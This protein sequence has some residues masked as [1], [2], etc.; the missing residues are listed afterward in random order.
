MQGLAL[1]A[2]A[3]GICQA[4]TRCQMRQELKMDK[5]FLEKGATRGEPG[6]QLLWPCALSPIINN[7]QVGSRMVPGLRGLNN[8]L[9]QTCGHPTDGGCRL[10]VRCPRV[11][12]WVRWGHGVLPWL[13][14]L[15]PSLTPD[16]MWTPSPR[17]FV[18]PSVEVLTRSSSSGFILA[19]GLM[20]ARSTL[21][22]WLF[23]SLLAACSCS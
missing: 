2:L 23:W 19:G 6:L 21:M 15:V 20:Q 8:L 16:L 5:F 12:S 1:S 3:Q 10:A 22:G 9:L 4:S 18:V 17:T 13:R 7:S 11:Q 14:D